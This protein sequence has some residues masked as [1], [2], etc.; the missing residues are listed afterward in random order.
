MDEFDQIYKERE[1]FAIQSSLIQMEL[2]LMLEKTKKIE[3]IIRQQIRSHVSDTDFY[4]PD[5]ETEKEMP[6]KKRAKK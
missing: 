6:L 5:I 3:E 1:D 4:Q 2:E